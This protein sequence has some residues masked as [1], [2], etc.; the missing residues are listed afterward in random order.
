MAARHF[1]KVEVAG[2]IPVRGAWGKWEIEEPLS[3]F[4]NW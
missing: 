3:H 4:D 1:V 2:S